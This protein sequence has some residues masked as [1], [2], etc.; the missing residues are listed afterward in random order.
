MADSVQLSREVRA[1]LLAKPTRCRR[2]L[3][4][5]SAHDMST[6]NSTTR[7]IFEILAKQPGPAEILAYEF[8]IECGI[9]HDMIDPTALGANTPLVYAKLLE[10]LQVDSASASGP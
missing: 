10:L 2:L 3:F 6:N 9:P 4:I 8:P 1:Q 5:T 7:S